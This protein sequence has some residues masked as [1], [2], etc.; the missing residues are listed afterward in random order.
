MT[1]RTRLLL[2]LFTAGTLSLQSCALPYI[3]SELDRLGS[4]A[5]AKE[6]G[7]AETTV[8]SGPGRERI[9]LRVESSGGAVIQAGEAVE[10]TAS[11]RVERT[12][13]PVEDLVYFWRVNGVP[14]EDGGTIIL[15]TQ[16]YESGMVYVV[17]AYTEIDG[18][19]IDVT[20]SIRV[21]AC[22]E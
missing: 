13:E 3:A 12:G 21:C 16:E 14:A 5:I 2:A 8:E 10:L 4:E 18:I 11:A 17:S 9:T 7:S 15:Q 19:D 22:K 20:L 6:T 1:L